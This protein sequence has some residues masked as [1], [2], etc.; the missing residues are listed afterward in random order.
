[1]AMMRE[2]DTPSDAALGWQHAC[3]SSSDGHHIVAPDPM[4]PKRVELSKM[5]FIEPGLNPVTSALCK[6]MPQAP[7]WVT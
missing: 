3:G 5:L 4:A 2:E 7:S 6:H 1:M